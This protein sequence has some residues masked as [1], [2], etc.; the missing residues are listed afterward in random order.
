LKFRPRQPFTF[1][2]PLLVVACQSVAAQ[3][4]SPE[5]AVEV[6]TVPELPLSIQQAA[7]V[8]T[9]KGVALRCQLSNGSDDEMSGLRYAL[10][11]EQ[12]FESPRFV[13]NRSEGFKLKAYET[14]IV[15]FQTP[16]R[17]TLKRGQRIVLMLDQAVGKHSIW[18]V[19]KARDALTAYLSGDYSVVP[20]VL[21]VANQ[22]DAPLTPRIIYR[23]K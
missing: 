22:I 19:V 7:L 3:S 16:L 17:V 8:K 14:R 2:L 21:R 23:Q 5:F 9:E 12:P 4:K 10:V 18:E 11:V 13:L 1:L 15:T 20:S 6:F